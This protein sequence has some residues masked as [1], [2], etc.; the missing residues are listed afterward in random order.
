[1]TRTEP[2]VNNLKMG[3]NFYHFNGTVLHSNYLEESCGFM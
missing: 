3:M 1:M 2:L